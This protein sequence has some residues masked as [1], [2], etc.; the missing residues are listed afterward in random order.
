M[1]R[2]TKS[3][4]KSKSKKQSAVDEIILNGGK[5]GGK[6]Y[7][8]LMDAMEVDIMEP[9]EGWAEITVFMETEDNHIFKDDE[10]QR[11]K[12]VVHVKLRRK[13]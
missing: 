9:Y 13:T 10:L 7:N 6:I 4:K 11:S 8:D 3:S 1:R 5:T 2:K 12:V